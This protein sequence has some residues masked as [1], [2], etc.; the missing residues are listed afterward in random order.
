MVKKRRTGPAAV[1]LCDGFRLNGRK[2]MA[3]VEP[4]VRVRQLGERLFS[5]LRAGIRLAG[6]VEAKREWLDGTGDVEAH[7]DIQRPRRDGAE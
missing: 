1:S 2:Q 7:E 3:H 6:R 5:D 4:D